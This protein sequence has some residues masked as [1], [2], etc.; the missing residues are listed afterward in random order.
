MVTFKSDIP[1]KADKWLKDI[2]KHAEAATRRAMVKTGLVGEIRVKAIIEKEAYDTGAGLR[3]VHHTITKKGDELRLSLSASAA[4]M[5]FVEEGRKPG[6]WPNLNALVKWVGRQLRRKGVNT[7]VNV[8]FDQLKQLARTGGRPANAAQ[9]AARQHLAM[10]YLVGR[11]I[12]TRGIKEK[13]IF[14]RL[15]AGM[16]AFFRA[17]LLK[18]LKSVGD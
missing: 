12:A 5:I 1:E 13:M 6:K 11:K 15:E 8:T 9:Q 16:L 10:L 2:E 3:S 7:R 4:H 14:K 18:E 17:E